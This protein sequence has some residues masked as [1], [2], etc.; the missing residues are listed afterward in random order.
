VAKPLSG[1]QSLLG[2]SKCSLGSN[3]TNIMNE[4]RLSLNSLENIRVE[5]RKVT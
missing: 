5:R 2:I 3:C 4:E 1:I